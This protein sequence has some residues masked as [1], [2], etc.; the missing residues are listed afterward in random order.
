MS[1]ITFNKLFVDLTLLAI[2]IFMPL[3]VSLVL[4]IAIIAISIEAAA[5][6]VVMLYIPWP[7]LAAIGFRFY[8]I[9]M[10]KNLE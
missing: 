8:R 1:E 10:E 5:L 7:I 3:V 4:V 9:E 2:G 6:F